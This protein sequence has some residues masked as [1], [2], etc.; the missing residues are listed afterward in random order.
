MYIIRILCDI[1]SDLLNCV[2]LEA[3]VTD[4]SVVQRALVMSFV[5][6]YT[7]AESCATRFSLST[8][9]RTSQ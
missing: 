8:I 7:F 5:P 6:G 2:I 9:G 3:N 4:V 1:R